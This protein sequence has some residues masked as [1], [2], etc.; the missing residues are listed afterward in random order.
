MHSPLRFVTS[1]VAVA[2]LSTSMVIASDNSLELWYDQPAQ[3]WTDALPIGNGYMGGMVFGRTE[4]ERLQFNDDTVWSGHPEDYINAKA[5]P[6][7][8]AKVRETLLAG[9]QRTAS[10]MAEDLMSSPLHQQ[11]YQP[12][13]DLLLDFGHKDV[14]QYRRWLDLTTATAGVSYQCNGVT[15]NREYLASYPD[16]VIAVRLSADQPGKLSFTASLTTPQK[17]TG[18]QA[19]ADNNTGTLV[20]KA[21]VK[22]LDEVE[23]VL[24]IEGRARLVTEG[25]KLTTQDNKLVVE[26]A[27]SA[28]LYLVTGTSYRDYEHVDADPTALCDQRLAKVQGQSYDAIRKTHLADYQALF[29]RCTLVLG[30]G[31]GPDM[32]TDDRIL[33]NVSKPD[34]ALETLTFQYGRYLLIASSRPGSQPA[35]LQ[36]V[37]NESLAPP[38]E[39]KYTTNINTEMNYWIAE[40]TNLSECHEPLLAMVDDLSHTGQRIASQHY[41]MPGWVFHHNA[42]GWR[43]AAA[44]NATDH[45]L[46]PVG[47]A[48]LS[49]HLWWHYQFTGDEQFLREQAYPVL[50]KSCQFYLAWL[51]DEPKFDQGWLISGPSNSPERGGLVMAP[52]MDHQILRFLFLNTARAADTLGVDTEFAEQLRTAHDRLAPNQIGSQGQL[53]EWLYK[54]EP[55]TT[56]RHVSHLWGLHPGEEITPADT[57]ELAKACEQTLTLRGDGGTSWSMAWKVNFWARL[58]DGD[59]A[60]LMSNNF[61]KLTSSSKTEYH[62][63]GV[64]SNLFSAHPPFQID[65]NFGYTSGIVEML[66]QSHRRTDDGRI[67]IDVLPALPSVWP[68]G[69]VTGLR[70]RGGYEVSIAWKEGKMTQIEVKSNVGTP[71][72]LEYQG[73]QYDLTTDAGQSTIVKPE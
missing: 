29:N 18:Q 2:L 48:W 38:W 62:G 61:L 34:P 11:A 8:L 68:D 33:A 42:D 19:T 14:S 37:W 12:F 32:P 47:G 15:Y 5:G 16:R 51:I 66:L 35:T 30:D 57:P 59:H 64:Y 25:G 65:G 73:K 50:K 17:L 67:I 72:V 6:E 53:K 70:A 7:Q 24:D 31:T 26:G 36:G 20:I 27:T 41:G 49:Q 21:H 28:T 4:V 40:L 54:E 22:N 52:T 1:V 43:G 55:N 10:K 39:S 60:H 9:D 71:A 56:H 58:L 13:G 69:K 46:W 45:G 3:Q 23:S 44:I 63:G